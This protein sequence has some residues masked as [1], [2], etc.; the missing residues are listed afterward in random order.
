[1][2]GLPRI[3]TYISSSIISGEYRTVP[4]SLQ[5]PL[6]AGWSCPPNLPLWV[7]GL[8]LQRLRKAASVLICLTSLPSPSPGRP[9]CRFILSRIFNSDHQA[10]HVPDHIRCKSV[11]NLW[12]RVQ[13]A[14]QPQPG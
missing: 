2:G 10:R 1:M 6:K 14:P 8:A 9:T 5:P 13:G 12:L 4:G 11:E 7:D 3:P